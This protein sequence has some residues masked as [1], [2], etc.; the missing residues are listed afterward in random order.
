MRPLISVILCYMLFP[1]FLFSEPIEFSELWNRV[2]ENSSAQKAKHSEW[3]ASEIAKSRSDQ[4][5]LPRIYADVR[6][7]RTND[8]GLNFMGKLGQRSVTESDFSTQS[9]RTRPGNFLDS[10][11]QPYTNLNSDTMNVFAKDQLNDPGYNTYSKAALGLDLP[12]YEGGAGENLRRIQDKKTTAL[13]LEK[14]S[15]KDKEYSRSGY[16]YRGIQSVNDYL[17]KL[18]DT[19]KANVRFLQS[20]GLR[21]RS[22]PVGYSGYL[23]LKNLDHRLSSMISEANAC[24]YEW[25]ENLSVL[26]GMSSSDLFLQDENLFSFMEKYFPKGESDES[27]FSKSMTHYAE[28]EEIKS[29]LEMSKFLPKFGLYSETNT[30]GGSRNTQSAYNAG[31]YLQMNLYHPKDQGVVEEAKLNAY[32]FRQKLEELKKQEDLK[33]KSLNR[34]E[35]S[36]KESYS[37]ISDSVRYQEEQNEYM[38]KLYQNGNVNAMQFAEALNRSA[39]TY[40]RLLEVELGLLQVRTEQ[41]MFRQKESIHEKK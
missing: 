31:V 15:V 38:L 10:N 21:H 8:P 18:E 16:L 36:L 12:L 32:A 24:L 5:W 22:N 17:K 34:Q 1:G 39:D 30:Y 19:K 3:K 9:M 28:G 33:I 25:K 4:H 20:Y 11:N 29:D 23:A 27:N 35:I 40:S 26:S 41:Y 13:F 6:T 2:L 14:E 7:Y 37:L